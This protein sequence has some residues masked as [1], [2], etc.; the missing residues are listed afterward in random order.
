MSPTNEDEILNILSSM[1]NSAAG[2][3]GIDDIRAVKG[4]AVD[5]LTPLTHICNLSLAMGKIPSALKIARRVPKTKCQTTD[6]SLFC[7]LFQRFLKN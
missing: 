6:L 2:H 1:K 3:D 7:Q 4:V 5:I